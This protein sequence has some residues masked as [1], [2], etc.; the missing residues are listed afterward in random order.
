VFLL[1][2][3]TRHDR[4]GHTSSCIRFFFFLLLLFL[5]LSSF[6]ATYSSIS[7]PSPLLL[8]LLSLK[9]L[10]SPSFLV[11]V[12]PPL[13]FSIISR[14]L[15]DS[16]DEDTVH[17]LPLSLVSPPKK[18][19]KKIGRNTEEDIQFFFLLSFSAPTHSP[20]IFCS[21]DCATICCVK[22]SLARPPSLRRAPF[23]SSTRARLIVCR[24]REQRAEEEALSSKKVKTH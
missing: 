1:R 23:L 21:Y 14:R 11:L 22:C 12:E 8:L 6:L 17:N 20:S 16:I 18:I 24:P 4:F 2:S 15:Q 5:S 13:Q 19:E 10:P 9:T 3:K 7:R